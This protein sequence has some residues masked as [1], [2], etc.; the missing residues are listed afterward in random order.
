MIGPHYT[1]TAD[2][3]VLTPL[4]IGTGDVRKFKR[5]DGDNEKPEVALTA[6]DGAGRP[7]L[8]GASIKGVLRQLVSQKTNRELLFG[9]D[10][11]ND[12]PGAKAGLAIVWNA[13]FHS[14][15]ANAEHAPY[16]N[17]SFCG[18]AET[19][20]ERGLFIDARTAIDPK[21]GVAAHHKLFHQ[22]LVLPGTRF[23]FSL[24]LH[25]RVGADVVALAE[26]LASLLGQMASKDGIALGRGTRTGQ[27]RVR[28][29]ASTVKVVTV[30]KSMTDGADIK[31][32]LETATPKPLVDTS[33]HALH[34]L[35]LVCNGPYL[36]S[37][38]SRLRKPTKAEDQRKEPHLHPLLEPDGNAPRLPGS[39][40]VGVLRTRALW[41][42][43]LS[44]PE[45]K[46][47]RDRKLKPDEDPAD[48][49][50]VERLF[51]IAGWSGLVRIDKVR[52]VGKAQTA[53]V[54]TKD[55]TSVRLDRFSGAPIDNAL[56]TT[57]A[58]LGPEF[59]VCLSL[60]DRPY[61]HKGLE[62]QALQREDCELFRALIR[63][64][65]DEGL[66]LGHGTNKGYGWFT[67]TAKTEGLA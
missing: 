47:C 23:A 56:F 46:D 60:T 39:S 4:H 1:L 57:R 65:K 55:I 16:G 66:M 12:G 24:T 33:L 59:E 63:N 45:V 50:T 20:V 54:P 30:P 18:D 38:S 28:L 22:M 67:V 9:P 29:E 27:G 51:G 5:F 36:V 10:E 44:D 26:V 43:A 19:F 3:K 48:L 13:R 17:K 25:N 61:R 21:A 42:M 64:L 35:R 41:L 11:I 62:K 52:F 8:P 34:V 2:L 31:R 58:W 37:D 14:A 6:L 7:Y 15:P 49:S 32:I 40:L 53:D